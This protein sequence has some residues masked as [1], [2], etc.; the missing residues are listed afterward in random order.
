MLNR[1]LGCVRMIATVLSLSFFAFAQ[2]N[3]GSD[4]PAPS[5]DEQAL[6]SLVTKYFDI[7]L[8]KDLEIFDALWSRH[9]PTAAPQRQ[10]LRQMFATYTYSFQDTAISRL[11]IQESKASL[12]ISTVRIARDSITGTMNMNEMRLDLSFIKEGPDWKLWAEVPAV[13]SLSNSL[14]AVNTDAERE[15][16][17]AGDPDSVTSQLLSIL[18]SRSDLAYRQS[19]YN[20][21]FNLL[22]AMLLVARRLGDQKEEAGVWQNI[23]IIHFVQTH[24][25]QALEAY[26][27]CLSIN[28]ELGRRSE[29]A[30]SLVNIGL[31]HSATE[32]PTEA[33]EYLQRGLKIQE[34]LGEEFNVAQTLDNIGA[35]HFEQGDY[36][37]ASEVYQRGV[38][39]YEAIGIKD[40]IV[41]RL[42]KIAQAE[43]GQGHDVAAI[44][45]Y[46]RALTKL[47]ELGEAARR[48]HALHSIANIYYE[49]GDYPQA[50]TYY[51]RS[52]NAEEKAGGRQGAARALQGVGLVH[53]LNGNY[54]MSL[55]AYN[56]NLSIV[57]TLG[58]K[59]ETA[60]AFQKV[61]G[62]FFKLSDH[63]KALDAYQQA[64]AL[65]R[66]IGEV[67]EIA[68]ALLDVGITQATMGNY[69]QAL[70]QYEQG[71]ELFKSVGNWAGVASAFLNTSVIYY[72]Q[73]DLA[74]ALEIAGQAGDAAKLGNDMD[75]F[76]QARYRAGKAYYRMEQ[77]EQA[78]RAFSE[79]V[80]LIETKLSPAGRARQP[81]FY[82]NKLAPY[83]GMIDV[84]IALN[85]GNEAFN[86]AERA[87][88]RTLLGIIQSANVWINKTMTSQEKEQ[89][90][91]LLSQISMLAAQIYREYE[92]EKPKQT[93]IDG[94]N[95][96][97]QKARL[98]YNTFKN[99]LYLAHPQLKI[100]RGEGKP[101]TVN[102]AAALVTDT[103][104]AILDFVE[105]D[106][107]LY[108]FVFTK[109]PERPARSRRESDQTQPATSPSSALKIY[110]I[111]TNRAELAAQISSYRN[112]MMTRS[113]QIQEGARALYDLI[114]KPAQAQ[115]QGR[116]QLVIS[117]D[118]IFWDLPFQSLQAEN[119]RFLIED[120]AISY[121]PSLT[122]LSVIMKSR[123]ARTGRD[124]SPELL[125]FGSP[126]PAPDGMARVNAML[127]VD[128]PP[129][130]SETPT[131]IE[132][133]GQLFGAE[134]SRVFTGPEAS[135]ERFKVEAGKYRLLYLGA[136]G[137]LNESS[138]LYS[139]VALMS[140]GNTQEDG[141]LEA[142]E[143]L[144]L[145]LK[146]ELI[147]MP[148]SELASAKGGSGRVMIALAW[149]SF[150]A[151]CPSILAGQWRVQSPA[152][153]DLMLE[154]YR[155]LK[156]LQRGGSGSVVKSE[157]WRSAT[158]HLLSQENYRHPYF[159]AG[160]DV[161][162]DGN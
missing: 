158:R 77:Y 69:A 112:L 107:H 129:G 139:I 8:K 41:N 23:G 90:R 92:R 17:L 140:A 44:N 124:S 35:V 119:N 5:T 133:L 4:T 25:P 74:K 137:V 135:E 3:S 61:G 11:K 94:L 27:K 47:E 31:V 156:P 136:R 57:Q 132:A 109:D 82:E 152:T 50:L 19:D 84:L 114:V 34:E 30:Q 106:E 122:T 123:R 91:Q 105:T 70:E 98:D 117:P 76:W 65:R 153:S 147:V 18:G 49:Q 89:E 20:K 72:L 66:E 103:K 54:A 155:R 79:A 115:L 62:A 14:A 68:G 143:L 75:L 161:M 148:S 138:P 121:T 29:I 97:W 64:L 28:E 46:Q 71:R 159:W 33:L 55:E 134:R 149:S 162:G 60:E 67:R 78:R 104:K 100:L 26:Q 39:L 113:P 154:F 37:P 157:A 120:Y 51:Q 40:V 10:T 22:Q 42:F 32:R 81:R 15:A 85:R 1:A 160:F 58:D 53:S 95:A 146:A 80:D 150:I 108:L 88:A 131:E 83:L 128:Q 73:E 116:T 7:Y 111:G 87:R 127:S 102:Q 56:K 99:R 125:A 24:Y 13:S 86:F 36:A 101:L 52:L 151:G 59:T 2:S 145:D 126:A 43:Y 63:A 48:G 141:L 130:S 45:F 16:L 110:V 38:K 6:R 96:K 144:G 118:M 93:R 12:H 21:A 142:R 9:A